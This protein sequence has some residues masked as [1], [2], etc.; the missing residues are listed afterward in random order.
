MKLFDDPQQ[1]KHVWKVREAGLGATA[2]IPGKPDTWEGWE[3]S[4]VPPERLGDYLRDLDKLAKRYDY[5]S[6]TYG[7]FGH[8]CVHTRWN[9][10]FVH[11]RRASRRSAASSTRR[12]TSWSSSAARSPASTATASRRPS[13]CRRCSAR[14]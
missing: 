7:H 9:F 6:S 5:E 8:G 14:S 11:A 2:F 13:S 3:D 4:A 12:R 1:E 10:D